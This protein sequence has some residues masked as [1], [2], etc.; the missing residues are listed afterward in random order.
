MINVD[1]LHEVVKAS[2]RQKYINGLSGIRGSCVRIWDKVQGW[3]G[4]ALIGFFTAV[5]AYL[6]DI[7]QATVFDWKVGSHPR[8]K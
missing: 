1:W 8:L 6:V 3:V 5:V 4:V 7:A 2:A